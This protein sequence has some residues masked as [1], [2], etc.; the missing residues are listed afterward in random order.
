MKTPALLAAFALATL[1]FPFPA[2]AEEYDTTPAPPEQAKAPASSNVKEVIVICKTHFDLGYTHRVKDLIPYYRTTMIDRALATMERGKALP[3]EQQFAWTAPGWVMAKVME[4]WDGQTP[5]RKRQLDEA[6]AQ[7]KFITHALPFTHESDACE[8]EEMAR[9]L[10]F[11]SALARKTGKPLPGAAKVTDVPGHSGALST[12]L[13]QGGVKFLHI[14]CNW[15]AGFVRTPGLFW[16]EGPDGSRT[17]TMYSVSYGTCDAFWPK[18]WV[19]GDHREMQ[20]GSGLMPPA[21]WPYTVWPAIIVTPDNSGP[22][23]EAG[24]RAYFADAQRKMPGV[25]FRMGTMEEFAEAIVK[26]K[27]AIPVVKGQMPDTWIH[28]ILADPE[29]CKLSRAAHPL[30]AS[31]EAQRTQLRAWGLALPSPKAQVASAYENILLYGEHTFG[32]SAAVNVYGEAFKK[33][34]PAK[35]ADLEGSWKDKFDYI[36]KAHGIARTLTRENLEALAKAVKCKEGEA[37][38]YN[39]LPW[40]RTETVD[41]HGQ[42]IAASD[43]PA[44]GYK[45]VPMPPPVEARKP[46]QPSADPLTIENDSFKV[47]L[48]P[49]RGGLT[50]I[51]DKRTGRELLDAS[52]HGLGYLN[53]RFSYQQT[54]DY[55]TADMADRTV[56]SFG[57]G[58]NSWLHPNMY[59]PGLPAKVPY[60]AASPKDGKVIRWHHDDTAT[61]ILPADEANH[62]PATELR[63]ALPPGQP[64]IELELTIKDK[65]KDNWPEADWIRLPFKL[66]GPKFSVGRALGEMDPTK[67]ILPGANQ[68]LYTVGHGL[69]ITGDDGAGV[70]VCPLDH[71]L[72]SLDRPG[73]WKFSR[74]FTPKKPEV[75]INL[76]NNQ[77]NTNFPYWAPGTHSSRVRI[78]TFGKDTPAAA[79]LAVPA[80]EA[81]NPLQVVVADANPAGTLPP[82]CAGIA[83]SRPGV[84]VT[85]FGEDPDGHPGTLLRVWEMAGTSGGLVVTL[86]EGVRAAKATP[87][88]LRGEPLPGPAG[89]ALEI[90]DGRLAFPLKA[91]APASFRLE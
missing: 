23:N 53:E 70:A 67:D 5:E 71:N 62:L 33:Y 2:A 46:P 32:G 89:A 36:A 49:R 84:V 58:K 55:V 80:L 83:V 82:E 74:D 6:F 45:V 68:D 47:T 79:R 91:W 7:G 90:K 43:I 88:D 29:G 63:V 78:W 19:P 56:G 15:P 69:T 60:R 28:G 65:P 52:D 87:V 76:Y 77:W 64:F 44:C 54:L 57:M 86:P 38:V 4:D 50:S 61:L 1:A 18:D 42:R 25:K 22:P 12:V 17:L 66:S 20:Y 59:K 31:A 11:A 3:K 26:E 75:F 37:V 41:F 16:W 27:A 34:D 48:D 51:V 14:G 9:G 73:C 40:K 13:S 24:V 35:I 85:A 10:V 39:P 81:R 72:V 21:D 8:A 30:V